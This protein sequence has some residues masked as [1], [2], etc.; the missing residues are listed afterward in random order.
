MEDTINSPRILDYATPAGRRKSAISPLVAAA[1]S[2]LGGLFGA[3][4]LLW[5]V[6]GIVW[7][8]G[9]WKRWK[10]LDGSDIFGVALCLLIG[11]VSAVFSVRWLR[12]SIK[13]ADRATRG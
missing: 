5:G 4:M 12:W 9:E 6:T 3:L 10:F 11:A 1:F 7:L 8:V 2:I 13:G